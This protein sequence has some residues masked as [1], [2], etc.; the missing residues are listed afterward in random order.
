MKEK[1]ALLEVEK[2]QFKRIRS[3]IDNTRSFVE[4][5]TFT[6]ENENLETTLKVHVDVKDKVEAEPKS[7]LEDAADIQANLSN[8]Q[9]TSSNHSELTVLPL[10]PPPTLDQPLNLIVVDT[11]IWNP[12]NRSSMN[13]H[14]SPTTLNTSTVDSDSAF[15]SSTLGTSSAL[16]SLDS[17]ALQHSP[18]Y[19]TTKESNDADID[20]VV[21]GYDD[22]E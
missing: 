11:T 12:L 21:K 20:R 19:P 15:P 6:D 16:N 5:G 22:Y 9:S 2:M 14:T 4:V 18:L 10:I 7:A 13:S 3:N 1:E 17:M 8:D